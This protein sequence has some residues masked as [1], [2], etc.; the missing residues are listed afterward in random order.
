MS[1]PHHDNLACMLDPET[2]CTACLVAELREI[3][4]RMAC[5]ADGVSF[6]PLPWDD[7]PWYEP[8]GEVA[9]W[10]NNARRTYGS[11]TPVH[12]P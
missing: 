11:D 6:E 3:I 5:R 12:V 1:K 2:T 4:I 7:P 10:Y 8:L 9:S